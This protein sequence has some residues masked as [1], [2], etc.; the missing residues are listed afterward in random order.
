MVHHTVDFR[1]CFKLPLPISN[2]RQWSND[3]ERTSDTLTDYFLQERDGLDGFAETHLISKDA[4]LSVNKKNNFLTKIPSSPTGHL[5]RFNFD[6]HDSEFGLEMNYITQ[7][8]IKKLHVLLDSS[9]SYNASLIFNESESADLKTNM[10]GNPTLVPQ[11]TLSIS[12]AP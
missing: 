5:V 12:T 1:P 6:S 11:Y 10:I 4:V 2:G 7:L 3:Q 9:N 8:P